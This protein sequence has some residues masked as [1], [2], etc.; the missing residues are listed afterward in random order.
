MKLGIQERCTDR[1]EIAERL[2]SH[3]SRYGD[4]KTDLKEYI[5]PMSFFT[6]L[7]NVRKKG[8]E[9]LHVVEPADEFAVQQPRNLNG[10]KLESTA[11]DGIR[12]G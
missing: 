11:K 5:G 3:T 7:E 9:V 10:K 4:E 2:R 6:V 12:S 8:H 1:T